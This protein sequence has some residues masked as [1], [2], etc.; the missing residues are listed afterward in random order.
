[1]I[2]RILLVLIAITSVSGCVQKSSEQRIAEAKEKYAAES[3]GSYRAP[4]TSRKGIN[5]LLRLE[6]STQAGT[7]ISALLNATNKT[8]TISG[9]VFYFVDRIDASEG[10]ES[11]VFGRKVDGET[12]LIFIQ[13]DN[14][15]IFLT[16]YNPKITLEFACKPFRE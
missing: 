5:P 6:C 7:R 2:N 10:G 8:V 4:S 14:I 12:S 16:I 9:A 13:P 15:P 1:M 11:L 3:G